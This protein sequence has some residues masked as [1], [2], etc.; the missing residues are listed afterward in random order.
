MRWGA[1]SSPT[2]PQQYRTLSNPSADGPRGRADGGRKLERELGRSGGNHTC[3]VDCGR[4]SKIC[5]GTLPP[6]GGGNV[7][8]VIQKVET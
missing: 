4:P 2:T 5:T 1:T 3:V 8:A 6:T 7:E